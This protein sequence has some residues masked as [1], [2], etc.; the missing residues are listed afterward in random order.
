MA[1]K[2]LTTIA[3]FVLLLLPLL[4]LSFFAHTVYHQIILLLSGIG[5]GWFAYYVAD[6]IAEKTRLCREVFLQAYEIKKAKETLE[7]C[8]A[9]DTETNVYS[10]RLLDSRLKEECD[11][12][13]RYLRPLS[14]LLIA[15]D[16]YETLSETHGTVLTGVIVQEVMHFLKENTR[17]VD[18]IVRQGESRFIAILPETPLNPSRIVAERIRYAIEKNIFETEGKKIKVT[19]SIGLSSFDPAIHR[20]KEDVL[21]SLERALQEAKKLGSNRIAAISSESL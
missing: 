2:I 4:A 3:I 18:I 21:K 9:N 6:L 7:S 14:F 13:R 17:S 8:L 16:Q 20:G 1:K 10:A 15:I 11:R 12:A 19:V 5:L